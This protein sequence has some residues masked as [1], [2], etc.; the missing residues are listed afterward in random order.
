MGEFHQDH[1]KKYNN[2]IRGDESQ[3]QWE[4]IPLTNFILKVFL[5]MTYL[6]RQKVT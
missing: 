1:L 5:F 4:L 2:Y 6:I 3:T